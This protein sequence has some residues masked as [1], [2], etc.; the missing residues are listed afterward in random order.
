MSLL[1][2]VCEASLSKQG[3]CQLENIQKCCVTYCDQSPLDVTLLTCRVH[4]TLPAATVAISEV[5]SP[6]A[7]TPTEGRAS[8][9]PPCKLHILHLC[10][11]I[12]T[13]FSTNMFFNPVNLVL[14][15]KIF[16]TYLLL[17]CTFPKKV[18]LSELKP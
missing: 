18:S 4:L 16:S 2:E 17:I 8:Q 10:L 7:Y 14:L 11:Q 3:T 15:A 1:K 13:K 9:I 12:K 5:L 6:W